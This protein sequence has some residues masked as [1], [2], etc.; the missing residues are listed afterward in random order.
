MDTSNKQK[1][2]AANLYN[3]GKHTVKNTQYLYI[4]IQ[5]ITILISHS[6]TPGLSVAPSVLIWHHLTL[7][8]RAFPSSLFRGLAWCWWRRRRGFP[9]RNMAPANWLLSQVRNTTAEH[10]SS[11]SHVGVFDTAPRRRS[12]EQVVQGCRRLTS[13]IMMSFHK[14]GRY[15]VNSH[16]VSDIVQD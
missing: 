3:I 5:Y 4:Y 12:R 11:C 13:T 7:S 16:F 1:Q 14:C 8:L 6:L 15:V 10:R 2:N 9:E